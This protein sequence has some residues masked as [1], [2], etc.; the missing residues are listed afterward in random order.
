MVLNRA[1][2]KRYMCTDGQVDPVQYICSNSIIAAM[3]VTRLEAVSVVF[4]RD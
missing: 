4:F 1:T 3:A 2:P